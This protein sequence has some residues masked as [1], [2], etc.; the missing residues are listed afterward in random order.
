MGASCHSTTDEC[1]TA[2]LRPGLFNA[3]APGSD[4]GGGD[5]DETPVAS[6]SGPSA[7]DTDVTVTS[8]SVSQPGS[9]EDIIDDSADDIIDDSADNGAD[10]IIDDSAGTV[11][12]AKDTVQTMGQPA[13]DAENLQDSLAASDA[14][15]VISSEDVIAAKAPSSV[16]PEFPVFKSEAKSSRKEFAERLEDMSVPIAA[17]VLAGGV[18][19]AYMSGFFGGAGGRLGAGITGGISGDSGGGGGGAHAGD[20][21]EGSATA[22]A[23]LRPGNLVRRTSTST[24]IDMSSAGSPVASPLWRGRMGEIYIALDELSVMAKESTNSAVLVRTGGADKGSSSSK[25]A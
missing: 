15:P 17:V 21:T 16:E 22:T 18:A 13:D 9:A 25:P 1:C 11:A 12:D 14:I 4:G 8:P 6:M 20:V 7:T 10:E 2:P 19:A 3:S 5:S 23:T 24:K